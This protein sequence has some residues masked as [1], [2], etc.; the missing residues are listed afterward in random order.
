MNPSTRC[1]QETHFRFKDTNRLKVKGQRR[2]AIQKMYQP[3]GSVA[4]LT[5]DKTV[6]KTKIVTKDKEAHFMMIEG[7]TVRKTKQLETYRNLET[8]PKST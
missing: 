5:S 1:L 8:E 4:I 3:K 7:Q 2:Y 6:S